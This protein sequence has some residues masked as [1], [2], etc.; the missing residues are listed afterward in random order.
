L[1]VYIRNGT[2]F[3]HETSLAGWT[4]LGSGSYTSAGQF[5]PTFVDIPDFV[6]DPGG[7]YGITVVTLQGGMSYTNGSNTYTSGPLTLS[8]GSGGSMSGVPGSGTET[9]SFVNT[10]RTWNG[11]I[12]ADELPGTVPEPSSLGLMGVTLAGL[13][14]L[15]K[16]QRA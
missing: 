12:Y 16:R 6:L 5:N 13:G 1:Q 8:T 9:C 14:L 2:Y 10:P 3:G 7:P 4:Y 11:T 15:R